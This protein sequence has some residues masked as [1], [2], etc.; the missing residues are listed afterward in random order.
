MF[1]F[2]EGPHSPLRGLKKGLRNWHS[3]ALILVWWYTNKYFKTSLLIEEALLCVAF[4]EL[5]GVNTPN[6]GD[7]KPQWGIPMH[8][9]EMSITVQYFHQADWG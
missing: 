1:C 4:A 2:P 9:W 6:L 5:C 3:Q 7:V 8:S